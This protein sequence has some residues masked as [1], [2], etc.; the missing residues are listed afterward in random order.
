VGS[1]LTYTDTAVTNDQT[2]YYTITATNAAGES[3]SSNEVSAKPTAP[4]MK[5]MVVDV[6]TDKTTYT[7]G[8]TVTVT[9]T[10]QDS[11]NG[12][13]IQGA[14]V[15]VTII[16]PRGKTLWTGSSTTNSFGSSTLTYRL[17]NAPQ[18]GTYSITATV[19]Y[20][21]YSTGSDQTTITVK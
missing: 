10:A 19:T 14:S 5:A 1:A 15:K 11:G 21:G 18:K 2:Y 17:S 16:D 6:K 20:S 8:T 13:P 3:T 4:V 12:T 9:V 7:R